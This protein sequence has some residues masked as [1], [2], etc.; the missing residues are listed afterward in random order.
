MEESNYVNNIKPSSEWK[1]LI[2]KTL[3]KI[4]FNLFHIPKL[5][6]IFIYPCL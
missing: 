3:S 5:H 2:S 1:L 4:A 6:P